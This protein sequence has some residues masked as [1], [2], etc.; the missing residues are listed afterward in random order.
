MSI[1][2]GLAWIASLEVAVAGCV[3]ETDLARRDLP[4][5]TAGDAGGSC[6]GTGDGSQCADD[7]GKFDGPSEASDGGADPDGM[8]M[9]MK[10]D[11]HDCD[12]APP[13]DAGS[14]MMEW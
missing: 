7:A 1:V 14:S 2:R 4:A 12:A 8:G 11:G 9:G 3:M 6:T 10:C 13:S 5:S